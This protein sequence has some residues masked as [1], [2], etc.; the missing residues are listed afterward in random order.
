MARPPSPDVV[1]PRVHVIGAGISGLLA[2]HVLQERGVSVRVSDKG[3]GVGGRM[4]TRRVGEAC[5]DHGAQFFTINEAAFGARAERWI[6]DGVITRWCDG[7]VDDSGSRRTG[8]RVAWRGARGMTGAPK[9]LAADLDVRTAERVLHVERDGDAH[10][11][12]F[13]DGSRARARAVLVTAPVPQAL[14]MLRA[15]GTAPAAAQADRLDAIAYDPCLALLVRL[16]GPSRIPPPGGVRL[17]TG[18]I[19]WM[20]DNHRKGISGEA[21]AV[22]IHASAAWSA[23]HFE[24]AEESIATLLLEAARPWLGVP[25]QQ[26]QLQRWRYSLPRSRLTRPFAVVHDAPPLLLAG[27][28]FGGG[29]VEGAALSGLAAGAWL[30][31]RI[32]GTQ[33][34]E[35]S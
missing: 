16:G 29:A 20:A 34:S 14:A 10:V 8:G 27:D 12:A 17:E 2:A 15:G 4:A 26:W 3:R 32:V 33:G 25:A 19:A 1:Q 23:A 22:T 11:L 31:D 24:D 6:D 9:A 7:F 35:I 30:A 18:P 13:E 21:G 28:A 5:F